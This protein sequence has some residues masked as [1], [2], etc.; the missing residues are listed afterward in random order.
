MVELFNRLFVAPERWDYVR[1]HQIAIWLF[2]GIALEGILGLLIPDF[3]S[4]TSVT[5]SLPVW[6]AYAVYGTFAFGGGIVLQGLCQGNNKNEAAGLVLVGTAGIIQF[7]ASIETFNVTT[8][9]GATLTFFVTI[10]ILSRAIQIASGRSSE[11]VRQEDLEE[12]RRLTHE[13]K[14]MR[15]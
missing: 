13:I 2:I 11:V 10:G 1:D 5:Q 8:L 7:I 9:T 15:D 4:G 6:M 12:L 3:R 14:K